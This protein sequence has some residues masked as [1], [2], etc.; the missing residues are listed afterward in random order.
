MILANENF[1]LKTLELLK[2]IPLNT[3][4]AQAVL[5]KKVNGFLYVNNLENP[6]TFYIYH[7]YGMAFLFGDNN[8]ESFNFKLIKYM[9]KNENRKK[10]SGFKFI[11]VFGKKP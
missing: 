8:N 1:Y 3:L 6:M 11:L 7:P 5:E 2:T 10:L 9:T 4:F